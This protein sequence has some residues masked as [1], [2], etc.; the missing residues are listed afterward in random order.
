MRPGVVWT[1]L[2]LCLSLVGVTLAQV[3]GANTA[4]EGQSGAPVLAG[5]WVNS[6]PAT[7]NVT[8]IA[9][10]HTD[11]G[12]LVH[13]WAACRP[14]DCD[15]G[16]TAA[17]VWNGSL[18][19]NYELG[20]K[21]NHIQ[22]VPRP[23][24][25]LVLIQR[26]EYH[27][28]SDRGGDARAELFARVSAPTVNSGT[29]SQQ[30][31]GRVASTYRQLPS[32]RFIYTHTEDV[33]RDTAVA[34]TVVTYDVHFSPPNRWRKEWHWKG[35]RRVEIADGTTVYTVYPETNEFRKVPQ[36][37]S[38]PWAQLFDY[39]SLDNTRFTPEVERHERVGDLECV[40]VRLNLGRGVTQRLWIDPVAQLVR[41]D[42]S[43][44]PEG[45]SEIVF[46]TVQF[47]AAP[48]EAFTFD[49]ATA[50]ARDRA[51][52]ERDA[53]DSLV[54]QVAPDIELRDLEC[55]LVRIR[56]LR[57]KVVLLDFWATWCV[58][59]RVALPTLELYHRAFGGKDLV[60]F[61]VNAE[62][63]AIASGYLAKEGFTFGS[64]VDS[65]EDAER[66]FRVFVWPTQVLINRDGTVGL[67]VRGTDDLKLRSALRAAG[68]W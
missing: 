41:K 32:A 43:D 19:A 15:W 31:L 39:A 55:R 16:E 10:R 9:I 36:G 61:G 48:Q 7:Q 64:L 3:G 33:L 28:G 34:R 4:Q 47:E 26:S 65:T 67:Y 50:R 60:V 37:A 21:T 18:V 14:S 57:G 1:S 58:P 35:E 27:D 53:P 30:L 6:T 11:A 66:A 56:D 63:P 22:L 25:G 51:E 2:S 17:E 52:A 12:L 8:E 49:P 54:G 20:F 62:T 24:G 68:V 5:R 44:G 42:V 45:T 46:S 23:E 59:C 38:G 13:I 29:E 40:V